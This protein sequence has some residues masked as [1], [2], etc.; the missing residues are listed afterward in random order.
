MD[1]FA[2]HL[3]EREIQEDAQGSIVAYDGS[4]VKSTL[5]LGEG[6]FKR[7]SLPQVAFRETKVE[8]EGEPELVE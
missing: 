5:E 7:L 8:E 6:A 4:S 1:Q 3:R 2:R